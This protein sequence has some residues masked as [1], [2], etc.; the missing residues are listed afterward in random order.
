MSPSHTTD[1]VE[2]ASLKEKNEVSSSQNT[3]TA[4]PEY[5][6][7]EKTDL[8]LKTEAEPQQTT[9]DEET[10]S[11]PGGLKLFLLASVTHLSPSSWIFLYV[12]IEC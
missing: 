2:K 11:Y 9:Q 8:E 6:G 7:S 1:M 12:W 4:S 5:A 3:L 10:V